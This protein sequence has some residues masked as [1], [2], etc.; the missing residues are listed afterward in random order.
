VLEGNFEV[1]D[2]NVDHLGGRPKPTST[3]KPDKE[4]KKKKKKKRGPNKWLPM[5]RQVDEEAL[6]RLVEGLSDICAKQHF[7][8]V[9]LWGQ[10]GL[11]ATYPDL[12]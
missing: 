12:T 9:S 7:R 8:E 11:L 5:K 6:E 2:L 10:M 3:S 1:G 4:K